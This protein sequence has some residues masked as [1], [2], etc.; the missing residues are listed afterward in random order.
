MGTIELPPKI[1]KSRGP[2]YSEFADFVKFLRNFEQ[3][4]R[5]LRNPVL[6]TIVNLQMLSNFCEILNK[7]CVN[8]VLP[9]IVNLQE[10]HC[11]LA[12][13]L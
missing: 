7:H 9:T 3:T 8:P 6:P 11:A 1:E 10:Q 13:S 12:N 5:K 2:H 4:L